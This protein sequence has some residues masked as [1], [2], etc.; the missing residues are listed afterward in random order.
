MINDILNEELSIS[1][2]VKNLTLKIKNL[3][4]ND[5]AR[6]I[7]FDRCY[8]TLYK[9]LNI[10]VFSDEIDINY[11]NIHITVLF[12]I[13]ED[14]TPEIIKK[15]KTIFHSSSNN[16][17]FKLTLY[18]TANNGKINWKNNSNDLQH[19]VEH[20]FQLF[21]KGK[22]L[23]SDKQFAIYDK[24]RTLTSSDDFFDQVIGFTYYYFTKTEKNA[25]IN[26][27]Y[28]E[29]MELNTDGA[30]MDPLEIIKNSPYY[31]NIQIIKNA[32]QD[33]D[34]YDFFEQ[35]LKIVNKTLKQFL[36]VANTM[37]NEYTKAFG[38]LLYK[39]KKDIES[40]NEDLL[41]NL[42][43]RRITNF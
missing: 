37:I 12:Y 2:D 19:E 34:N 14:A 13:L 7:G 10:E 4:S 3:I 8:T 22:E 15:Y 11:E 20:L 43:N 40:V 6:N 38:R 25:I 26:G 39:V 32:I 42:S 1:N 30:I 28:G 9:G 17:H 16:K 18:L 29:I 23:L 41:I 5:Y 21:K 35:R 36:R 31:R 33:K 24:L 27:L